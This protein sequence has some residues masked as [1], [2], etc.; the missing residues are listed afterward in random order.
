[1][2]RFPLRK[3][4]SLACAIVSIALLT[5]CAG[6]SKQVAAPPLQAIL[7]DK[8]PGAQ[9]LTAEDQDAIDI[10]VARAC[11]AEGYA[12]AS[13]ARHNAASAERRE[14]LAATWCAP[15]DLALTTFIEEGLELVDQTSP[16]PGVLREVWAEGGTWVV[17]E[18]NEEQL[19]AVRQGAGAYPAI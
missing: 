17:T 2:K 11:A 4:L 18:R 7:G 6:T 15:V 8:L 19:C 9:G 3:P 14:E 16:G 10:T 12:R 13:C 5:G 1:M